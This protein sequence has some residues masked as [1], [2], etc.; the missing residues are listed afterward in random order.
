[1]SSDSPPCKVGAN[2]TDDFDPNELF[3]GVAPKKPDPDSDSHSI[4]ADE[5]Y[6]S[7][8]VTYA[9][10]AWAEAM[11]R[12]KEEA[13]SEGAA[14]VPTVRSPPTPTVTAPVVSAR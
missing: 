7:K 1:M 4:T 9:Y 11:Q 12:E 2:L 10:D 3:T 14:T 5:V 13:A 8:P 6:L